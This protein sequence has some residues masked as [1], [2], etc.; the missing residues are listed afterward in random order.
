M[1]QVS[2]QIRFVSS[3]PLPEI[4]AA[5]GE[6]LTKLNGKLSQQQNN[7]STILGSQLKTRLLGGMFLSNEMLP[8]KVSVEVQDGSGERRVF[9]TAEDCLGF[10]STAGMISRYQIWC[11]QLSERVRDDLQYRLGESSK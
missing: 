7:I 11:V 4:I 10:G 9:V 2:Q 8:T 6:I 1:S 3:K 5:A